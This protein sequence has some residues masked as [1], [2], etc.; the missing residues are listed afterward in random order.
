V[1][2]EEA[3]AGRGIG[4]DG[5]LAVAVVLGPGPVGPLVV[6]EDVVDARLASVDV[7]ELAAQER[8]GVRDLFRGSRELGR[9]RR[10]PR[11]GHAVVAR[12]RRERELVEEPPA[13]EGNAKKTFPQCELK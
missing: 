6:V 4:D 13:M 5:A 9:R 11:V 10:H 2:E 1:V 3:V 12:R 7:R 8:R